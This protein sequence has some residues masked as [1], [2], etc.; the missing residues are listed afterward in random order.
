M[1]YDAVADRYHE[2]V[3]DRSIIHR[4]SIPALV[5]MCGSGQDVLDLGCGQGVLAR[6]LARLG[7]TVVGVDASTELLRPARAPVS[8][9]RR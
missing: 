8:T 4:I 1:G 6:E 9:R 2:F 7:R 3:R 5:S